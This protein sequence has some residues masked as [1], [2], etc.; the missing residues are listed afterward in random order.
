VVVPPTFGFPAVPPLLLLGAPPGFRAFPHSF[1]LQTT[2]HAPKLLQLVASPVE[3]LVQLYFPD[4]SV[5]IN[6]PSIIQ[7]RSIAVLVETSLATTTGFAKASVTKMPMLTSAKT[8][9]TSF[10]INFPLLENG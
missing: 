1:W 10:R 3:R 5:V 6:P 8:A 4:G 9:A 7:L 2:S